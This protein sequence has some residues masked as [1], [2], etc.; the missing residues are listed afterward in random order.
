[1]GKKCH[2]MP[3]IFSVVFNGRLEQPHKIVSLCVNAGLLRGDR[4]KSSMY[5]LRVQCF[6]E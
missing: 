3:R 4:E 2:L 1:M 6:S 5:K